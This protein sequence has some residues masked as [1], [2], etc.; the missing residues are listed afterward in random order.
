MQYGTMCNADFMSV[1]DIINYARRAEEIGLDIIWLPELMGRDPFVMA[2]II[3]GNTASINVG[4]AIANMYARDARATKSAALSLADAYDNRF[5]LGLGLSNPVGVVP[6]GHE[7]LPPVRKATDFLDLYDAADIFFKHNASVPRYLAAHGPKLMDL[8]AERLDG[9][10]TYLQTVEYSK[11]AKAKLGN[12]KLHL[13]QPT[14]FAADPTSARELAR[15]AISIYMPLKN[16]HRAW[17]ERGFSDTDFADGGSD[18]F[19]DALIAWG[20]KQRILAR[21]TEQAE[22]GIDQIIVIPAG[23]NLQEDTGWTTFKEVIA[24]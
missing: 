7:W 23:I 14:I 12:K 16:Y 5:E 6:R 10:Y 15:K 21:Y 24:P 4:T 11:E 22:A 1:E 19:I 8:A 2:S 18:E 13:M 9:A 3:L 20:D 17:R